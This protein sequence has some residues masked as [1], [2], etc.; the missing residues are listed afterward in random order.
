[1]ISCVAI[2]N[3]LLVVYAKVPVQKIFGSSVSVRNYVGGKKIET[4][5]A[6]M[7][8]LKRVA[9][10][11]RQTTAR[12]G[13]GKFKISIIKFGLRFGRGVRSYVVETGAEP[14]NRCYI[15]RPTNEVEWGGQ[16]NVVVAE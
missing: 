16:D 9:S 7:R 8:S 15:L 14:Y 13:K 12:A 5:I 1:M 2:E 3:F 10:G 11:M 4:N 6:N